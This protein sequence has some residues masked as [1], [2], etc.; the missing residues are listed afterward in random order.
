MNKKP[1]NELGGRSLLEA[2]LVPTAIYVKP[3]LDL[4]ERIKVKGISHITG[5]GFYENI[6]RSVPSGLCAAIEKSAV[7][8]PAIFGIIREAGGIPERDMF[9]TF[10]MGVGMSVVVSPDDADK[11]LEIL[12]SDGVEAYVIGGIEKAEESIRLC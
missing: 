11:A 9:N 8:V 4:L 6:P 1:V 7:K 5:G 3:V 12:R 10:N 2:L